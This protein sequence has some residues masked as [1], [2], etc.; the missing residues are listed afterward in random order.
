MNTE[1]LYISDEQFFNYCKENRLL[2]DTQ[3]EVL[4][5][6]AV[7]VDHIFLDYFVPIQKIDDMI[8]YCK[9]KVEYYAHCQGNFDKA[10]CYNDFIN[11]LKCLSIDAEEY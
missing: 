4:K 5:L 6:A 2:D 9:D 8:K 7:N 11:M 3:I 1:N 10:N